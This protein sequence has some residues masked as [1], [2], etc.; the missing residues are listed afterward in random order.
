[1]RK[2]RIVHVSEVKK[3]AEQKKK[4]RSK[5]LGKGVRFQNEPQDDSV[6]PLMV[7]VC[8]TVCEDFY[9]TANNVELYD[10]GAIFLYYFKKNGELRRQPVAYISNVV[11]ISS[12][13]VS[14]A[15]EELK[16]FEQ[17]FAYKPPECKAALQSNQSSSSQSVAC[18]TPRD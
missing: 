14:N 10:T 6:Y 13:H 2:N 5:T 9:I 4:Y 12:R 11:S 7:Y 8:K 16:K 3:Y 15:S 1:M 17:G 18:D